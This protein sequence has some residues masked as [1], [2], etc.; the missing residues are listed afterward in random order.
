MAKTVLMT[1]PNAT[2]NMKEVDL[3][4]SF[5]S[6]TTFCLYFLKKICTSALK[7]SLEEI[8]VMRS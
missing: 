7:A 8:I 1:K 6:N 3:N 5:T 2:F 4:E